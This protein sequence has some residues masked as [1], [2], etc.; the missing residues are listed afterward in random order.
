MGHVHLLLHRVLYPEVHG[1]NHKKKD[2]DIDACRLCDH[3]H[4]KVPK[5]MFA[6][7]EPEMAFVIKLLLP[8]WW[9]P[10]LWLL[11][12]STMATM[13]ASSRPG[14][15]SDSWK[16]STSTTS[17]GSRQMRIWKPGRSDG[18]SY[19][20]RISEKARRWRGG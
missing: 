16:A 7:I 5:A 20:A 14:T 4:Q 17:V 6:P 15:M 9:S 13:A 2:S 8:P 10:S 12:I 11:C 3:Y 18:S 19:V 1:G